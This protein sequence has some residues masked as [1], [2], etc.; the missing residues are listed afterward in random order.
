MLL[1]EDPFDETPSIL[2]RTVA[3]HGFDG[4]TLLAGQAVV[5]GH[6][7]LAWLLNR[8]PLTAP[9]PLPTQPIALAA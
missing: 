3:V 7:G 2:R 8:K 9:S 5:G 4:V 1:W 6:F